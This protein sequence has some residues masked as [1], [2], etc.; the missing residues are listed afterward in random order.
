M[1]TDVVTLAH[2]RLHSK[3]CQD[4]QQ[5]I[6]DDITND[7][8][9][10]KIATTALSTKVFTEDDLHDI[11]HVICLLYSETSCLVQRRMRHKT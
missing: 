4:L 3:Q 1:L 9:L 10:I 8:I 11:T 7:A 2:R 6:L 5:V